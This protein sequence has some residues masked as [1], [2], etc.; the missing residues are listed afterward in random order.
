VDDILQM[1]VTQYD[2]IRS[3]PFGGSIMEVDMKGSLLI[4]IINTGVKN[5]GSGGFLQ[6]SASLNNNNNTWSLNN[7][8]VDA[9]KTYKVA[10]TD[11]L[12]TGG[13][14]NMD[15]LTKDNPDIVKV[16]P[17]FTDL[18]DSRSDVRRAIIR[19]MEGFVK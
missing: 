19:Y 13:E 9:G 12:M 10:I 4:K 15:F 6:Y 3:L 1:P 8:P 2:V 5:A 17:V 11:F 7:T 16:Y 18:N 14:A